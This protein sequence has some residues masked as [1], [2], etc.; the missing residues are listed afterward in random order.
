[1]VCLLILS[2]ETSLYHNKSRSPVSLNCKLCSR[3]NELTVV[4]LTYIRHIAEI[5][6]AL[7]AFT[8]VTVPSHSLTVGIIPWLRHSQHLPHNFCY[9]ISPPSPFVCNLSK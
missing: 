5:L 2:S 9:L 4:G 6:S 3:K 8:S 1:M 7:P